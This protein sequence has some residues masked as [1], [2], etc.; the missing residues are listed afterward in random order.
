MAKFKYVEHKN[1]TQPV[2]VFQFCSPIVL[3]WS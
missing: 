2:A 3:N 1:I